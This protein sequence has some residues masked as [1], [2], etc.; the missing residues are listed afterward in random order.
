MNYDVDEY[1]NAIDEY[2]NPIAAVE[3]DFAR[4]PGT[5]VAD[6]IDKT[7]TARVGHVLVEHIAPQVAAANEARYQENVNRAE[8]SFFKQYP[9][10]REHQKELKAEIDADPS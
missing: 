5:T 4:A 10:A 6:L 7:V 2:G 8:A 9:R 3:V 1:G